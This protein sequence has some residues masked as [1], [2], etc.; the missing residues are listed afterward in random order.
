MRTLVLE[1]VFLTFF[2]CP[3]IALIKC[4]KHSLEVSCIVLYSQTGWL[5]TKGRCREYQVSKK[6]TTSE[7]GKPWQDE[8]TSRIRN[9]AWVGCFICGPV[10]GTV[11]L[12]G[13]AKP[14]CYGERGRERGRGGTDICHHRHCR[15]WRTFST[16]NTK[17]TVFFS[18]FFCDEITRYII[19][20]TK[21]SISYPL[22]MVYL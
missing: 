20:Y 8:M 3:D 7:N 13:S 9:T 14:D 11:L 2:S 22:F 6:P 10:S 18:N 4:L 16:E 1:L 21:C 15:Q 5:A 17:E 12:C 19:Q